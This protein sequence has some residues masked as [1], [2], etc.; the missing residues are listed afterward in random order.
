[1]DFAEYLENQTFQRKFI[2]ADFY[3]MDE[4]D[5]KGIVILVKVVELYKYEMYII[6]K[7][8]SHCFLVERWR[9]KWMIKVFVGVFFWMSIRFLRSSFVKGQ[10]S[11]RERY[12][13][14]GRVWYSNID[15]P[16]WKT[17]EHN[18]S[19][20][21]NEKSIFQQRLANITKRAAFSGR[22]S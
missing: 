14:R 18:S 11:S 22:M 1:M 6:L 2:I 7:S 10:V 8:A 3:E 15:A 9:R 21:Q 5:M 17:L 20:I 4:M 13:C 19:E 16:I 12:N